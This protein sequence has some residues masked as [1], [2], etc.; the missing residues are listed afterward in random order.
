[1]KCTKNCYYKVG[2]KCKY[3]E[4]CNAGVIAD[5]P[6]ACKNPLLE[7]IKFLKRGD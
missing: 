6:T 4:W 7:E 5:E 3:L 2:L 1:M